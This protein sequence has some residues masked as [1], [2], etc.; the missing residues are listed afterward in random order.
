MNFMY[1][2]ILASTLVFTLTIQGFSQ[3]SKCYKSW[4]KGE[5]DKAY[6]CSKQLLL[7]DETD[8]GA[9]FVMA[10]LSENNT[11]EDHYDLF[12]AFHYIRMAKSGLESLD[13]KQLIDLNKVMEDIKAKINKEYGE[14]EQKLVDSIRSKPSVARAERFANEF[15]D[16]Q[17]AQDIIQIRNTEFFK[18]V[19]KIDSVV[20]YNNFIERFPRATDIPEAIELR[21]KAAYRDLIANLTLKSTYDYLN[22]YP[23]SKLS[24]RV[25]EIRDSIEYQNAV[26]QNTSDAL[27]SFIKKFPDSKELD[28]TTN[29]YI[30]RKYEDAQ[31]RNS[32]G[33]YQ[34][35]INKYY[36]NSNFGPGAVKQRE[37]L[38]FDQV[39]SINTVVEYNKFI[40]LFPV[41]LRIREV[42]NLRNQKAFE[43]AKTNPSIETL[44]EFIYKYPSAPQVENALVIRDS[45]ILQ[46]CSSL[47][48]SDL[49]DKFMYFYPVLASKQ[50]ASEIREKLAFQDAEKENSID[51]YNDFL[52]DYPQV[53]SPY[54]AK[55]QK[56]LEKLTKKN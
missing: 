22:R 27:L 42:I 32:I 20:N 25:I 46:H 12:K 14:I 15:F 35:F 21:D 41:S 47:I 45:L 50:K 53:T 48:S 40:S 23:N 4:S 51:A 37:N 16:S 38:Y 26:N 54:R 28:N 7:S 10:L 39:K 29:L 17:F 33:D 31:R 36:N 3:T 18:V 19:K 52:K 56:A 55:A 34:E 30:Q 13:D 11:F 6:Q 9:N 1:K 2:T 49:F 8:P 24:G 44:E 43:D 5:Y